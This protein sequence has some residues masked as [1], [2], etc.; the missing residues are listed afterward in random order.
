[1]EYLL[2]GLAKN[3]AESY[4]E[5]LLLCT[6]NE[7]DIETVKELASEQGFHSFRVATYNGEKPNFANS[8][9]I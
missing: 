7:D 2:Y 9:N 5:D 8:L 4:M 3:T 1:M 6:E